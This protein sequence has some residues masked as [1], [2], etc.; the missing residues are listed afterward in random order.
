MLVHSKVGR[1]RKTYL[2]ADSNQ[3]KFFWEGTAIFLFQKKQEDFPLGISNGKM[4]LYIYMYKYVTPG[5]RKHPKWCMESPWNNSY[6]GYTWHGQS[7]YC[8][9]YLCHQ[10]GTW[11]F[12]ENETISYKSSSKTP[13]LCG[14]EMLTRSK[15]LSQSNVPNVIGGYRTIVINAVKHQM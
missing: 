15:M 13:P 1:I 3:Q 14:H 7:S 2:W 5:K 11:S 8:Y 4:C 10:E 12:Q 9:C 6:W